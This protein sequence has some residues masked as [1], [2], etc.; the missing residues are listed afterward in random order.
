MHGQRR[1]RTLAALRRRFLR[2]G[3][4][5]GLRG[6]APNRASSP[7]YSTGAGGE[8]RRARGHPGLV[9]GAATA[10]TSSPGDSPG[11]YSSGIAPFAEG[12]RPELH[13]L[14]VLHWLRVAGLWEATARTFAG[15]AH[16]PPTDGPRIRS[17][18]RHKEVPDDAW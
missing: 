7:D 2:L 17:Q 9:V 16:A 6:P 15:D 4:G 13:F 10:R 3:V 8:A 12:M 18:E 5:C 11:S 14:R 1:R